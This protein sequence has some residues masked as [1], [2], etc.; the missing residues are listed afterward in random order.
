MQ[1]ANE[2]V[3]QFDASLSPNMG[4]SKPVAVL[5]SNNQ[6]YY[7]KREHITGVNGQPIFENAVF[8][9]ELFVSQIANELQIPVPNCAILN[10]EDDFLKDNRDLAFRYHLTPG[11]YYGSEILP[12]VDNNLVSNYKEAISQHQPQIRRSWNSYFRKVS[13]ISIYPSIIALDLLTANFDRFSNEGNILIS[14]RNNKKVVY[15]FDFGHC[16]FFPF[17]NKDKIKLMQSIPETHQNYDQYVNF[18]IN[19]YLKVSNR[20]LEPLG[21]VFTGMQNN[22][23]FEHGNPFSDI[24]SRINNISPDKL[25]KF[26]KNVPEEWLDSD[27]QFQFDMYIQFIEKSKTIVIHLLDRLYELG[28]FSNSLGGTLKWK[29]K[30]TSYGIQ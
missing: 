2:Y 8:L 11:L 20:P 10:L 29:I 12:Q 18:I 24:M 6:K 16:F 13:N 9:Q 26:L 23:Y 28:A 25:V 14:K 3:D 1:I 19:N 7:L 5:A 22:I 27:K 15:T 4:M 21:T 17:W 30:G